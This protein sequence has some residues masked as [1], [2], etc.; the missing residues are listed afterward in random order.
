M[1]K[2]QTQSQKKLGSSANVIIGKKV[3]NQEYAKRSKAKIGEAN[4]INTGKVTPLT[5]RTGSDIQ[6]AVKEGVQRGSDI[7]APQHIIKQGEKVIK[8]YQLTGT[9]QP[10]ILSGE[11]VKKVDMPVS[12]IPNK[13]AITSEPV[14]TNN[15]NTDGDSNKYTI[16]V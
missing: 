8:G 3:F 6:N 4:I 11:G 13:S 9:V 5:V 10:D 2:A 1:D 7:T 15:H 12:H 16:T 14:N